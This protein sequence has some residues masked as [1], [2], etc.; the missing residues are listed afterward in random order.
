MVRA[1]NDDEVAGRAGDAARVM[2]P[3]RIPRQCRQ[4]RRTIGDRERFPNDRKSQRRKGGDLPIRHF[5]RDVQRG[6]AN[7][8]E[9]IDA[10]DG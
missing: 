6:V 5:Q 8:R 10:G 4:L 1:V 9:I 2:K 7:R 3:L